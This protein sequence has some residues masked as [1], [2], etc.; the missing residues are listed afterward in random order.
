MLDWSLPE[1]AT[2]LIMG[3]SLFHSRLNSREGAFDGSSMSQG[4]ILC[5][6]SFYE[7]SHNLYK[8]T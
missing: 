4:A 8:A 2:G 1:A 6:W 7:D 3:N 5:S